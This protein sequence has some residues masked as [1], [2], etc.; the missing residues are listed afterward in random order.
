MGATPG[1][2]REDPMESRAPIMNPPT[3]A[4]RAFLDADWSA[5][6]DLYPELGTVFGT[7]GYNDRW[8]DDSTA[9]IARRREQL[10]KSLSTVRTFRREELAPRTTRTSTSTGASSR[11]RWRAWRSA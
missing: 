2:P 3:S 1:G 9:G 10:E 5:W 11:T 6:L 8:T 4:F 7:P